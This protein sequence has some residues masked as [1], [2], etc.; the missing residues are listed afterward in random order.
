MDF[1]ISWVSNYWYVIFIVLEFTGS[2]INSLT[3]HYSHYKGFV[4]V[5]TVISEAISCIVSRGLMNNGYGKFKLPFQN[6]RPLTRQD[7]IK[8]LEKQLKQKGDK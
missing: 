5:L 6:V 4:R 2:V 3:K 1:I 7:I 8:Q